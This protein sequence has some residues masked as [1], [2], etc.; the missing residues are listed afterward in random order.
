[1]ANPAEGQ[2][3]AIMDSTSSNQRTLCFS[4]LLIFLFSLLFSLN[5]AAAGG[6]QQGFDFRNTAAFVTDPPGDTYVLPTMKYPTTANGVTFGWVK[7]SLVQGR[8]RNAKLDPRLS[9]VNFATN[10][11][12]ATLYVDLPSPGTYNLSLAL[13]DAGYQACWVQCQIQFLDGNTVVATVTKGSTNLGYFYD[14]AGNNWSAAAW[15]GSNVSQQVTLTGSRLTVVVGTNNASGDST[16]I[17]FLGV[18]QASGA[19]N[20]TI[21]A[22]PASLTVQQGN[23]GTSTITTAISGGFNSAIA[24]SASGVPSGTTVSFNPQTI[25]APGSGSSSMTITVGGS[26]PLGTYPITVTG[27]GGGI[28]QSTTVTLTVTAQQ[29]PNFAISASPAS[30]NIQQGN[31]GNSTITTT[32]SG[33]FNSAIALSASG[34]P[35]GTTVNFNPNPI[36]APGSGSSTMTITVG[37]S[38]PTGTYPLVVTGNGGGIQ[39]NTTVTLTVT[40]ASGWQQGFDF[41]STSNFV[42]DP[43]G[44]TYVLATTAYPTKGNGVTYGWL[45]T[46]LEQGR[47]RNAGVDPRLAGVNLITNGSPATFYVDVPAPGTYNLS[48]G[49]GDDSYEDCWKQCLIQF[50]DGNTV[51]ATVSEGLI[52]LGNFYDAT[53]KNWS[54]ATWPANNLSQQV[55]LTS[56]R[57]TVILG[58]NQ[59]TGDFT[60]I[61]F[62]GVAQGSSSPNFTLSASPTSLSI[63]QGNKGTSTITSTI[64]GGFRGAVSLSASGLPSGT[65]AKFSPNP[66]PSPGAGNSTMTVTVAGNTPTGTFPVTVTGNGGGIQQNTSVTLTV[67]GQSLT[68]AYFEQAYS[69]TLQSSFGT[70]PYTYQLTSGALPAGMTMDQNGNITGTPTAVGQFN[71]GVLVTDSSQPPQQQTFNFTLNVVLDL[72]QYGGLSAA[73]IHGCNPTGFFQLQKVSGRWLLATPSCDSFYQLAVYDADLN[74]VSKQGAAK[75]GGNWALWAT[76]SLNRME[77]YGFNA[78][79][80]YASTYTLPIPTTSGPGATPPMPFYVFWPSGN[81]VVI[82]WSELGLSAPVGNICSGQGQNGFNGYCGYTLDVF[83]PNWAQGN[84]A[85]L[86]IQV[87]GNNHPVFPQ[88]FA[89]SPWVIGITLSDTD[90]VFALKGNGDGG[91]PHPVQLAATGPASL[92]TKQAWV[93][94]L[95]GKYGTIGS[96]NTAWGSSYAAW[97]AVLNENGSGSWFGHDYYNQIG[98]TSGLKTDLDLFLRQYAAQVFSPQV[99][100]VHG[101]DPNHLL[102]CGPFGGNGDVGVRTPVLQGL[103]DAGCNVVV[104]MWDSTYPQTALA[105]NRA[106]YDL[107]GLP[108]VIWYGITSQA[109]SDMS[110]FPKNG[111]YDAD[112]P[113][114]LLRGQQYALDL[115]AILNAQATDGTYYGLGISDWSMTDNTSNETNWGLFSLND[116]AYDG[117]CAVIANSV[118]QWGY[119][120]GGETANYGDFLDSVTQTNS[121]VYQQLILQQL[122]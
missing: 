9:G 58:T 48:L 36:P 55:T 62:L 15:P 122:H 74:Y 94:Y 84:V 11:S 3:I 40:A 90:M 24:L 39:Q 81:D 107:T 1:M 59:A 72:D 65:T 120:C 60:P 117:R 31:Q 111:A 85:E 37:G 17:A 78:L 21:S 16:P 4:C 35:A 30:L 34:T 26:T 97:N 8:D 2:R 61:A 89:S 86:G 22:S 20:F 33:G 25:P 50:L 44:D 6:W 98:M 68:T 115:P 47:N 5:A 75:Y 82:H 109:D 49:M 45:K 7:T 80:I 108:I 105:T 52:N 29:Q 28:Q 64:S 23:Q 104:Q 92:Y 112:Y 88:G 87:T 95:K 91:Y 96:L 102:V 56:S 101:Y 77:S 121:T 41:R 69:Y 46:S 63:A 27:N 119:A 71:F 66:I 114:Q 93:S 79:D 106:V 83:D 32:I 54:A 19:P 110:A 57:L 38:T 13:G 18:A 118:D 53:G 10:G 113:T 14:M 42:T 76:H 43:P 51:V 116:N 73:P 99:A 12:P 103:V 100:V 70:P 67:T